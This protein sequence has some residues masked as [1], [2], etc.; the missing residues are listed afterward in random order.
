MYEHSIWLQFMVSNNVAEYEAV[1]HA[2]KIIKMLGVTM[3]KVKTY[4]QLLAQ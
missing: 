1:I 2:L 3:V 4:S